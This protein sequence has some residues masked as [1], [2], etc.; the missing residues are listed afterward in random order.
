MG[1]F[2]RVIANINGCAIETTNIEIINSWLYRVYEKLTTISDAQMNKEELEKYILGWSR[3]QYER[4]QFSKLGGSFWFLRDM[5]GSCRVK[6]DNT[7][8][9]LELNINP[10]LQTEYAINREKEI[11]ESNKRFLENA[12]PNCNTKL[13]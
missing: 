7:G 11:K 2:Q 3:Y 8:Y 1:K 5:I 4:S 13:D 12:T 10:K 9:K 6:N